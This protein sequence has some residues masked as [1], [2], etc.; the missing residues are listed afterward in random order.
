MWFL[1]MQA[2]LD[3]ERLFGSLIPDSEFVISTA[4]KWVHSF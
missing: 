1:Y 3:V 4:D 2:L